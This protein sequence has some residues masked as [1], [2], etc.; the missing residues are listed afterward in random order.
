[1]DRCKLC[2][3][4]FGTAESLEQHLQS[5]HPETYC[6]RCRRR[7]PHASAK[8]QHIAGSPQHHVCHNCSH[9]P[10]FRKKKELDEHQEIQHCGCVPSQ[11]DLEAHMKLLRPVDDSEQLSAIAAAPIVTGSVGKNH[12]ET[13]KADSA[14]RKAI[15]QHGLLAR[16]LSENRPPDNDHRVFY[17]VSAPTSTFTCGSQG[18]GKSHTLSTLL[19]NCL[20]SCEANQLPRPL[21]GLVFHYDTFIS[22]EG[23]LP[24]EAA[25]LSSNLQLKVRVLCPP[26]NITNMKRIYKEL[27]N[28]SV[29]ELRLCDSDLNTRRMI[30]L[31]AVSPGQNGQIPLYLH[32]VQRVLRDLRIRQ[33]Q[34]GGTFDYNGFKTTLNNETL[35]SSQCGPLQQCLDTLESFMVKR[36]PSVPIERVENGGGERNKSVAPGHHASAAS[37]AQEGTKW[38]PVWAVDYRRPLL[39]LHNS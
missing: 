22:D 32:V 15:D 33:Q 3:R 12:F 9:K 13:T 35:T 21:A 16:D 30:D 8:Q 18:S 7:F 10:D 4:N 38:T 6:S 34:V 25:W 14:G 36:V 1:M 24:C 23:G 28:V 19:E 37:E 31:M 5:R 17:N 11:D 29:H 27:P 26:T 39:P 2:D 20:L